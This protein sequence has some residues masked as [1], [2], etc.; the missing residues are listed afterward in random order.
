MQYIIRA[1]A[2]GGQKKEALQSEEPYSIVAS[3]KRLL[4][5]F[6]STM[7][8]ANAAYLDDAA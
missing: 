5:F 6:G 1:F 8:K 2:R 4:S 3:A 7:E